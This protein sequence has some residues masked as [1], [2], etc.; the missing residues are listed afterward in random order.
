[1]NDMEKICTLCID[2]ISLKSHL[3]YSVPDDKI[4][5][6]EDF[7]NGV[8]SKKIATSALVLL[9]RSISGNWKQSIGHTLVN[10][11]CPTDFLDGLIREAIEKLDAIGLRVLVV[12][13]KHLR[14]VCHGC[15]RDWSYQTHG[16]GLFYG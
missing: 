8:R 10:G 14:S 1:M 9:I 12:I 7:G 2:K 3:C 13:R 5:G 11:F 15:G 4:I 16:T 6:L